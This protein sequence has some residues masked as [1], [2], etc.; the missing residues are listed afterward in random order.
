MSTKF[1]VAHVFGLK[2]LSGLIVCG[3]PFSN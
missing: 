3:L 1:A 2:V